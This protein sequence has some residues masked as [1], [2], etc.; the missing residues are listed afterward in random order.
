VST[1]S[2]PDMYDEIQS[3]SN[4]E[5]EPLFKRGADINQ[6]WELSQDARDKFVQVRK[7]DIQHNGY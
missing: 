7:R 2:A 6:I 1:Q 5:V 3:P 4:F